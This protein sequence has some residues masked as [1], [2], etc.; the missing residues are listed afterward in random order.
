MLSPSF[1]NVDICHRHAWMG[2]LKIGQVTDCPTPTVDG[3][4][5]FFPILGSMKSLSFKGDGAQGWFDD[6]LLQ[7]FSEFNCNSKDMEMVMLDQVFI[8]EIQFIK[9][10]DKYG[11][12][13]TQLQPI[14]Y[15]TL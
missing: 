6:G 3:I 5:K 10:V 2:H 12:R 13:I 4:I 11:T 7:D 9:S 14:Q 1:I 8:N 15:G